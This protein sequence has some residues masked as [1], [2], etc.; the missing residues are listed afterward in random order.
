M[1][2]EKTSTTGPSPH[3]AG[4][5]ACR[6]SGFVAGPPR[7]SHASG[8]RVEYE[9]SVPCEHDWWHDEP[10]LPEYLTPANP[11]ALAACERG[12]AQGRRE[13]AAMRGEHE[14]ETPAL[15]GF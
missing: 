1:S 11:R 14:P 15:P 3:P 4:C 10:V 2:D 6:G 8:R 13:L 12:L 5:R 9:T 7:Y